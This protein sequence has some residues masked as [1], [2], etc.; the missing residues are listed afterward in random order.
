MDNK[1]TFVHY[2]TGTKLGDFPWEN[3]EQ[4]DYS[5]RFAVV[6]RVLND[7]YDAM[8]RLTGDYDENLIIFIDD[9]RFTQ[10]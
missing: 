6:Q 3:G 7:G 10:R 2:W 5:L 9:K 1:N 4:I 8:L